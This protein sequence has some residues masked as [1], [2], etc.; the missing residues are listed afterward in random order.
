MYIIVGYSNSILGLVWSGL[1]IIIFR[2]WWSQIGLVW[3]DWST[4]DKTLSFHY[5]FSFGWTRYFLINEFSDPKM[6]HLRK[7]Y[8]W[9]TTTQN[10]DR[11]QNKINLM[12]RLIETMSDWNTEMK[13]VYTTTS[14]QLYLPRASLMV[15]IIINFDDDGDLP[16]VKNK[17]IFF[18]LLF[19]SFETKWLINLIHTKLN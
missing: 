13:P 4:N 8:D 15:E 11:T 19:P 6:D 3:V 12:D 16:E 18:L 1:I 10:T 7:K 2:W 9:K 5:F 17:K 14:T